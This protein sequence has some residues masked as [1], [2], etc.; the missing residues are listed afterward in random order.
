MTIG[1]K[2]AK[3]LHSNISDKN[4]N[5]MSINCI[6]YVIQMQQNENRFYLCPPPT[7]LVSAYRKIVFKWCC[8]FHV[9]ELIVNT[10]H[11]EIVIIFRTTAQLLFRAKTTFSNLKYNGLELT[12]HTPHFVNPWCHR[13]RVIWFQESVD[14]QPVE[15]RNNKTHHIQMR[16]NKDVRL[17]PFA[18]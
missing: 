8:L 10:L 17:S 7:K 15:K 18:Y 16:T 6:K 12:L 1:L 5:K 3:H 14:T 11:N 4:Q 13:Y 9:I 2:L